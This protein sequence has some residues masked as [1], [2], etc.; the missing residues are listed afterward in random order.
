MDAAGAAD[1]WESGEAYEPYVGR[2]SRAVAHQFLAW[3][4]VPPGGRW[5]DVGCGTGAL[6]EVILAVTSPA[7]VLGIDPSAEYVAYAR[8]RL[9]DSRARFEV[10][11]AR[12]LPVQSAAFDS[13]VTGLALNF[14]PDPATAVTE[15]ARGPTRWR[16]G[17]L[18]LGLLRRH[19]ADSPVLGR[20]GGA[21][22]LGM[23]AGRGAPLRCHLQPR[24]VGRPLPQRR[25]ARGRG[26][27]RGR[28]NRVPRL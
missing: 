16:C 7:E 4:A 17:R 22:S 19:A 1:I 21:R 20:S 11:D 28:A 9:K 13:V 5:L 23:R 8:R 26:A 15:L 14:V 6:S 2:W 10:G 12:A 27:L 24:Y 18:C 3:L 25:T